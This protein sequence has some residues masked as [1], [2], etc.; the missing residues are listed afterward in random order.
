MSSKEV[1]GRLGPRIPKAHR[2]IW[3]LLHKDAKGTARFLAL[4][5]KRSDP[6]SPAIERVAL[7]HALALE[8]RCQTAI[9]ISS[10]KVPYP[11]LPLK[12]ELG[13]PKARYDV[14]AACRMIPG[15]LP[16]TEFDLPDVRYLRGYSIDN[17]PDAE[18]A[19]EL[20][21]RWHNWLWDTTFAV[22]DSTEVAVE[23]DR[24]DF[25]QSSELAL[26]SSRLAAGLKV[27]LDLK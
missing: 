16:Y 25:G 8:M 10:T 15:L 20:F 17:R 5:W 3:T 23:A 7:G 27:V 24:R 11:M 22:P 21:A 4:S 1:D 26:A 12:R 19:T 9:S 14:E 18:H 13:T 6:R 2:D